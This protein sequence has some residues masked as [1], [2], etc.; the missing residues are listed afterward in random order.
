MNV[1]SALTA[2]QSRSFEFLR[3]FLPHRAH[4]QYKA[5]QESLL[6]ND[7]GRPN[8]SSFVAYAYAAGLHLD[9]DVCV[10]HGWVFERPP[11]VQLKYV[12]VQLF[13]QLTPC[14]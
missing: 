9:K 5:A 2:I 6:I 7:L 14:R 3:G 11:K 8:V 12:A 13:S 1:N 10:S 4:Q